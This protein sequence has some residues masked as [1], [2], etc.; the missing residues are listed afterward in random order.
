MISFIPC[1]SLTSRYFHFPHFTDDTKDCT[2]S[3]TAM[4]AGFGSLVAD[5][6]FN[7]H[8]PTLL[9]IE[10]HSERVQVGRKIYKCHKM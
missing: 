3:R 6:I 2:Q 4:E 5:I 10:F 1:N 9:M 7:K 8:L